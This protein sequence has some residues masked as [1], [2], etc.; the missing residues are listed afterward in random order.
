MGQAGLVAAETGVAEKHG[1]ADA[2]QHAD[3]ATAAVP[4]GKALRTRCRVASM[5]VGSTTPYRRRRE[6][7]HP[8]MKSPAS[9]TRAVCLFLA[10][11]YALSENE[12]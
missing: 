3:A 12:K 11:P 6:W 1:G 10:F 2:E 4:V 5:A 9:P 8:H 7:G